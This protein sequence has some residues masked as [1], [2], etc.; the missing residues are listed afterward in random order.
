MNMNLEEE[1]WQETIADDT[2]HNEQW[3]FGSIAQIKANVY[4]L[5]LQQEATHIIQ[6]EKKNK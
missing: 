4:P 5:F 6:S 1:N 2:R 3:C